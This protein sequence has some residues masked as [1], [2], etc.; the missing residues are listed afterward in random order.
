MTVVTLEVAGQAGADGLRRHPDRGEGTKSGRFAFARGVTEPPAYE[1]FD[2]F[3]R[4]RGDFPSGELAKTRRL[5]RP[6]TL[7]RYAFLTR[8]GD[9]LDRVAF[10]ARGLLGLHYAGRDGTERTQ[11]FRAE[12][13]LVCA[14]GAALRGEPADLFIRAL[15][16]SVLL[17]A[18]RTAFEGLRAGHP[19]W[20]DLTRRLTE[21]L[22]LRQERR[23]RELLLD[24]AAT[25]Y[26]SFLKEEPAVARRLTQRQIASY[27]GVT[28]VALSRIRARLTSV[29]DT[30]AARP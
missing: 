12:G 30:S 22:Y 7:A 20:R 13:Q 19:A 4:G 29:N 16:E 2:V 6:V 17:V 24:D 18:S 10:V 26:L 23:Q 25:R 9:P 15:E 5:F 1:Q 28:P 8:A 11:G 21:D 3:L 27:I 14:Y